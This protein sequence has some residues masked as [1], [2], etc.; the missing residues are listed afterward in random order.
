MS[1]YEMCRP[2]VGLSKFV[3]VEEMLYVTG[4]NDLTTSHAK[5]AETDKILE[6]IEKAKID[7]PDS[8]DAGIFYESSQRRLIQVSNFSETL[9]LPVPLVEDEARQKTIET[10][11]KKN[12]G[13]I[14]T[15]R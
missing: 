15:R 5:L 9:H 4:V 7:K 2:A 6:E 13:F 1:V 10:F 8:V 3:R 14:V 12:K 11:Q